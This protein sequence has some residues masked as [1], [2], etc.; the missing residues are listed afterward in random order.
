AWL[1]W[2]RDTAADPAAALR[3]ARPVVARAFYLDD[4]QDLL[5]VRPFRALA[6]VVRR[7]DEQL[8]DGAVEGTG[9]G[10]LGLGQLVAALHSRG[11]PG[12][13]VAVLG[14]ALLIGA[15]AALAGVL[16]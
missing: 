5:V 12:Y 3:A 10:T 4:V 2:R 7:G 9:T 14:G 6:S 11:L 16:T 15:A 8:V 1:T 13:A